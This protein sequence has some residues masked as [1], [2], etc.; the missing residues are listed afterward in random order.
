MVA[1]LVGRVAV[2]TLDALVAVDIGL[3]AEIA[4]IRLSW[5]WAGVASS[6]ASKRATAGMAFLS[7]R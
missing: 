1:S 6:K 3:V 4:F 7:G 2:Q 5:A